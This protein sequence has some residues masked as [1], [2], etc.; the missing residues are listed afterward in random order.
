MLLLYYLKTCDTDVIVILL[1]FMVQFLDATPE[2]ELFVD[3]NTSK[4]KKYVSINYYYLSLGKE[5]C[6]GLPFFH[7]FTGADSTSSFFKRSKKEW[8]SHWMNF[9]LRASLNAAFRKLSRCPAEEDVHNSQEIIQKIVVY[10]SSKK[11]DCDLDELRFHLFQKFSSNE[12]R[13]FP[14]S[15]DALLQHTFRC[16]YQA[17][18]V[19]GNTLL[20]CTPPP[21]ELWG[22][23][24]HQGH[25]RIHWTSLDVHHDLRMS[26]QLASV[27]AELLNVTPANVQRIS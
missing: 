23:K 27:N 7:C 25:L 22:W 17:G 19:W 5:T 14:P 20:Q 16:A 8:Y 18:W 6:F 4:N 21:A 15:K 1:G 26:W 24:L 9:P 11:L 12:L 3:F 13:N 10:A 2:L